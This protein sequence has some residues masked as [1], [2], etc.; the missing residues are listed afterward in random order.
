MTEQLNQQFSAPLQTSVLRAI[1]REKI[2]SY[3]SDTFLSSINA[4]FEERQ[5]YLMYTTGRQSKRD[6]A[7][8]AKEERNQKIVE[9]RANGCTRQQIADAVGCHINTVDN[10]LKEYKPEIKQ[11]TDNTDDTKK[12][13]CRKPVQKDVKKSTIELYEQGYKQKEIAK[14]LG[15]AE[16]TV[17]DILKPYKKKISP[18]DCKIIELSK[19]GY[20][21]QQIA[22]II[23]CSKRTVINVL[24][25]YKENK[26]NVSVSER[27]KPVDDLATKQKQL[28]KNKNKA[29][30]SQEGDSES[31]VR[32]FKVEEIEI[33]NDS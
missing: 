17:S 14:E 2:Y 27:K 11:E 28:F 18:R 15:I 30:F 23:G 26:T 31:F 16:S 10:V 4:T 20:K 5:L 33:D 32:L 21:Q 29:E 24:K 3:S 1:F 9:L 6:K 7:K 12:Q 19:Q 25:E 8:K 22:D 13:K